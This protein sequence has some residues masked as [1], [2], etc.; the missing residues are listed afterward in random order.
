MSWKEDKARARGELPWIR[1]QWWRPYYVIS[2]SGEAP[3]SLNLKGVVHWAAFWQQVSRSSDQRRGIGQRRGTWKW[4]VG[5]FCDSREQ[6][7]QTTT[8]FKNSHHLLRGSITIHPV[9]ITAQTHQ[10]TPTGHLIIS[11]CPSSHIPQLLEA[12]WSYHLIFKFSLHRLLSSW[13]SHLCSGFTNHYAQVHIHLLRLHQVK[14]KSQNPKEYLCCTRSAPVGTREFAYDHQA[15]L[16]LC[17][18]SILS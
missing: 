18:A 3:A 8:R 17:M 12:K 11:G 10:S 2:W 4:N 1:P 9:C 16:H 5:K 15:S 13:Q 7:E 14:H 6:S